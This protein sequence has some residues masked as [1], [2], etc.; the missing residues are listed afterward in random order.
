MSKRI[1]SMLKTIEFNCNFTFKTGEIQSS[2]GRGR[3]NSIQYRF[4]ILFRKWLVSGLS[5]RKLLNTHMLDLIRK[6]ISRFPLMSYHHHLLWPF[7][8][9]PRAGPVCVAPYLLRKLNRKFNLYVGI[10]P[11]ASKLNP[12]LLNILILWLF[13]SIGSILIIN[14][15]FRTSEAHSA[16]AD[17]H[18]HTIQA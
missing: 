17:T 14:H 7:H 1:I 6:D 3:R 10:Q 2:V 15:S 11:N 13:H 5:L 16:Y 4:R 9:W 8:V 12:Y 18:T